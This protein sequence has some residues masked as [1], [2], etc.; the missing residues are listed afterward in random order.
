MVAKNQGEYM[1][2]G[3]GQLPEELKTKWIVTSPTKLIELRKSP[4]H[5]LANVIKGKREETKAMADGTLIHLA[6]LEYESFIEKYCTLPGIK[7]YS[8]DEL[9]EICKSHDLKVSGTKSELTERIQQKDPSFITFE[10]ES[11]RLINEGKTVLPQEK[12]DMLETIR[13]KVYSRKTSGYILPKAEKEA[14]GYCQLNDE[15]MMTFC[16]D[17]WMDYNGKGVLT[18]LKTGYDISSDKVMRGNYA[19]GRNIQ[20]ASYAYAL[21]KITGLDFEEMSYFLFVETNSP[22]CVAEYL[23]DNAMMDAG[24]SERDFLVKKLSDCYNKNHWPDPQEEIETTTLTSWDWN[25]ILRNEEH[26]I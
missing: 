24:H 19:E 20:I 18:D 23:V 5:Y 26:L 8:N 13:S 10:T 15:V 6:V 3:F 9:K 22:Y 25:K 11:Q 17:A 21:N 1:I 12:W 4:A 16:V 7:S 14:F 2:C